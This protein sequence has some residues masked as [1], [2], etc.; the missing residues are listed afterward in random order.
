[1]QFEDIL[2]PTFNRVDILE[3]EI[4]DDKNE[5]R[6]FGEKVVKVSETD[7]W[8]CIIRLYTYFQFR[9]KLV[10]QKDRD[11]ETLNVKYPLDDNVS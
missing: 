8:K 3:V 5:P 2:K 1:M 6:L 9:E 7:L 4:L 11:P 10:N